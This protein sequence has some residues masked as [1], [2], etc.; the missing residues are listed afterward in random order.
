MDDYKPNPPKTIPV[1]LEGR[2]TG[3]LVLDL[4]IRC[5]DP[6]EI[7]SKLMA[8][9]GEFLERA[10]A[11][12]PTIV[13]TAS[14]TAKGTPQGEVAQPLKR[15]PTEPLIN[16]D[17]F[18][19]F[20]GGELQTILNQGGVRELVV[21][22]SSTNVAVLYTATTA[23]RIHRY[24]VIVPVDGVNTKRPYEHEYSLHQLS[25]LPGDVGKR[26]RFTTLSMI[27]FT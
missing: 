27:Q 2:T 11:F 1:S 12:Q 25:I 14:A 16:P 8:P 9:L 7:C 20:T 18:D 24:P 19:K 13:Y 3:I 22:G 17:G 21:L 26:F 23:A 4:T 10:R 6:N 15:R 5:H